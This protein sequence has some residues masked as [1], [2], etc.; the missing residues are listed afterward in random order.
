MDV[1]SKLG[2]VDRKYL[3]R[4]VFGRLGARRREVLVGPKFGVDI[5]VLRVGGGNVLVA[6][7]DPLSLI[8]RLGTRDSAWLSVHLLASDLTTSGFAPQWGIFDFNLPPSMRDL[9]FASYWR[10]F[11]LEC[12]KLGLAIVGGHTGRYQGC[13]L[14]V[15]GGGVMCAIGRED[16]YLTSAMAEEG[17]DLILTKGPAIETTAVLARV[18]AKTVR[19]ALGSRLFEQAWR[20]LTKVSTVNDA[21]TAVSAGRHE[22][23]VTAMHDATEGGVIAAALELADASR[24]GVDLDLFSIEITEETRE[25]CK[26]FKIDPLI[27]LSEGSLLIACRPHRTSAVM[28]RLAA[29]GT[30]SQVIGRLTSNSGAAYGSMKRGRVRLRYPKFDPYW[31]AYWLATEKKLK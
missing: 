21:L 14:T 11:D 8:P 16:E 2:K 3:Q 29:G 6:S 17:D 25:L 18:F 27:S 9:E 23:G 5:A 10:A 28:R 24:L 1:R 7:T 26:L 20:Y 12:R 4:F 15:I 13:D 30:N 31:K 22:E 19:K